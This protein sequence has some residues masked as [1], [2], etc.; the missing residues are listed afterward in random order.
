MSFSNND[1]VSVM[2][3]RHEVMPL[4]AD[5]IAAYDV[6]CAELSCGIST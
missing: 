6:H 5:K 2:D 4:G 1:K 3:S